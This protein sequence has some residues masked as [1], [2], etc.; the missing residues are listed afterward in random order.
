ME[1]QLRNRLARIDRQI[2]ALDTAVAQGIA[3]DKQLARK[4]EVVRS[5]PGV[6]PVTVPVD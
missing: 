2:K 3:D 4:L 6:G 5:M 1:H